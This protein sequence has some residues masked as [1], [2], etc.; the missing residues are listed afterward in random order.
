M[1]TIQPGA[2]PLAAQKVRCFTEKP[3]HHGPAWPARL[4]QKASKELNRGQE[5]QEQKAKKAGTE[6]PTC[7][8]PWGG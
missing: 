3:Q 5:K 2:S 1:S 7:L 6:G 8:P 4:P